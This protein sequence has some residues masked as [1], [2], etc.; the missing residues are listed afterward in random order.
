MSAYVLSANLF[1]YRS[2]YSDFL[3]G[4]GDGHVEVDGEI[5]E[6]QISADATASA[7]SCARIVLRYRVMRSRRWSSHLRGRRCH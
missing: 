2:A 1:E 5:V 3:C 7:A 6:V 4:L